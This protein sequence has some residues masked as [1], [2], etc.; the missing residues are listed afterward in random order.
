MNWKI[1]AYWR[2]CPE[3]CTSALA[4]EW[5]VS[6]VINRVDHKKL[7]CVSCVEKNNF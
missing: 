6:G 3:A 2:A 7:L 4:L 5:L 1:T